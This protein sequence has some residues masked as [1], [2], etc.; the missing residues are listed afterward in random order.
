MR[1]QANTVFL[2]VGRGIQARPVLQVTGRGGIPRPAYPL[3]RPALFL[4]AFLFSFSLSAQNGDINLLRKINHPVNPGLDK[5]M[6]FTSNTV[7][8][9]CIG[10]PSGMLI[11]NLATKAEQ[12]QKMVPFVVGGAVISTS[13]ICLGLKYAVNRPRPFVT[14]SDIEQRDMHVGPYSF[15]SAHTGNAF[16][17]ATSLSLCYPKWY[18]IAPSFGWAI[19]VGYS[20][21]RLGV[22]YP[23]DVL[24]GALIGA[25]CGWASYEVNKMI[26]GR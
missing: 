11:Y 14:Y 6:R 17:L 19:A 2:K 22:H 4:L 10:I 5:A 20:R 7:G 24:V 3:R 8:P 13:A 16:A 1:L 23:T 15:P 26:A 9:L 18:V 25:G 21:M 12:P